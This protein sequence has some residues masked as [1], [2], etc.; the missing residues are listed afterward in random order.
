MKGKKLSLLLAGMLATSTMVGFVGCGPT[1][2]ETE[3]PDAST[4]TYV[5]LLHYD[6]GYGREYLEK[7]AAAFQEAV[8]DVEYEPGKKGVYIDIEHSKTSSTG[9]SLLQSLASSQYDVYLTSGIDPV[10][11]KKNGYIMDVSSLVNAKSSDAQSVSRF[12]DTTSIYDR[13]YTEMQDYYSNDDGSYYVTPVFL[14]SYNFFYDAE[15]VESKG[16]YIKDG[17]T[18]SELTFT[19]SYAAAAKGVDGVKGTADDGMPETYDQLYLWLAA[20]KDKGMIP[21][22]YSGLYQQHADF[23]L[24]QFWADFEG[25]E[26]AKACWSFDGTVMDDLINVSDNGTVSYLDPTA[27]TVENGYM[28]QKQEGRYRVLQLA[29][30]LADSM[31][32][33]KPLINTIAFSPSEN[34]TEAQ[35][36]YIT[37]KYTQ[38]PIM[39]FAEGSYW[40]AEASD[41]FASLESRK[42]GKLDRKFAVL[43]TPKYTRAEVGTD[44]RTTLLIS[45]G[46]SMLLH[47]NV[48]TQTN[49]Q[50]VKDFFMFFNKAENMD[51]QHAESS[52][53]RPFS[54]EI[55]STVS[56]T[57][58][59][60]L[61]NYHALL[62]NERTDVVFTCANNSFYRA[63]ID[64][65]DRYYWL[66]F[67]NYK[68]GT[69]Q[70]SYYT[71]K[72]FKENSNN[73]N[74][75]TAEDYFNGLYRQ[76]QGSWADWKAKV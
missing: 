21:I 19:K 12:A 55:D 67:S 36:T 7:T 58:S 15:L 76:A 23:A 40:E 14:L 65:L 74:L 6:A 38:Q 51:M 10:A 29:K 73:E 44:S 57:M 34:H 26:K 33:D 41:K 49:A 66:F 17:S 54:Y 59:H 45:A 61:K 69:D 25:Y 31:K 71:I 5:K 9:D 48:E 28:V 70:T 2:D 30:K 16:L 47:K 35:G 68:E 52:S 43:P 18:D 32:T 64:N 37:S 20:V 42:G 1:G 60:Y 63:N 24:Q 39:L 22:H 53:A 3:K 8:K 13:M 11:A 72:T 56:A 62:N 75:V 27:I 50:A 46:L 4:T